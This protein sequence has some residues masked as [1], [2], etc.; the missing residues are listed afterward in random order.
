M[1]DLQLYSAY[2]CLIMGQRST[3]QCCV[4]SAQ[5]CVLADQ[6]LNLLN[7]EHADGEPYTTL[8]TGLSRAAVLS[9]L[10]I[11]RVDV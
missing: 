9:E 11:A 10:A 1:H 2:L 7:G 4:P 8:L 6:T 5:R 3:P